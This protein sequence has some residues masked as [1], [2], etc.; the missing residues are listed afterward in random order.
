MCSS[1]LDN[2]HKRDSWITRQA[3]G[4]S[5]SQACYRLDTYV[6]QHAAETEMIQLQYM[7]RRVNTGVKETISCVKDQLHVLRFGKVAGFSHG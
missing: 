1:D 6:M 3:Q 5:S 4:N 7:D 2:T